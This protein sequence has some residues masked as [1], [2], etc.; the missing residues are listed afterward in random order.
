MNECL[1][2]PTVGEVHLE[3][4]F[5]LPISHPSFKILLKYHLLYKLIF[6]LPRK[7]SEI[8]LLGFLSTLYK[9]CLQPL[10]YLGIFFYFLFDHLTS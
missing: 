10:D 9:P 2:M 7:E 1:S 3:M 8:V 5:Y 4:N 6:N